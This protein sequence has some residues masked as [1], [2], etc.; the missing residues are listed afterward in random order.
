MGNRKYSTPVDIWSAGCIFA[1][2]HNGTPLFPGSSEDNQLDLIFKSIGTP[3][4]EIY[5]GVVDLPSYTPEKY[6]K[7]EAPSSLNHLVPRMSD[8]GVEL[9]Q[10]RTGYGKREI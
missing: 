5:P 10:V 7:Y 9:L 3:N 4:E 1:E 2:M 6:V 8:D